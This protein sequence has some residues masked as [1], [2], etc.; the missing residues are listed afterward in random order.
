M[1]I[2]IKIQYFGEAIMKKK[3]VLIRMLIV[4]AFLSGC[5]Q[6]QEPTASSLGCPPPP[7]DFLSSNLVGTWMAGR[8]DW[9]D[10]LII[11]ADGTYKQRLHLVSNTRNFDYESTWQMWQLE[12]QPNGIPY[13]HLTGYRV[14]AFWPDISCDQVGGGEGY[15]TDFCQEARTKVPGGGVTQG[16]G[17]QM[18]G[19]GILLVMGAPRTTQFPQG[20][21]LTLL[22]HGMYATWTFF[23]RNP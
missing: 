19:E 15:W 17:V 22:A 11:K 10:T 4:L 12:P 5:N 1:Q 13:L 2:N 3:T 16:K 20:I 9:S 23:P 8:S 21:N 6:E 18:P 14:C 7:E